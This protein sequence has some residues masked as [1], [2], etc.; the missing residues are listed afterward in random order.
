MNLTYDWAYFTRVLRLLWN[1]LCGVEL[2]T[3]ETWGH[4]EGVQKVPR[5][6]ICLLQST[7]HSHWPHCLNPSA[8]RRAM[9]RSQSCVSGGISDD[10]MLG[11]ARVI[12]CEQRESPWDQDASQL[13]GENNSRGVFKCLVFRKIS[14]TFHLSFEDYFCSV[15]GFKKWQTSA[16][17]LTKK[18]KT[19]GYGKK[20][21]FYLFYWMILE[22]SN[23]GIVACLIISLLQVE[24]MLDN[25]VHW[26]ECKSW[27]KEKKPKEQNKHKM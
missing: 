20:L 11:K 17:A 1:H 5:S 4:R 21:R 12:P 18:K 19:Q 26:Y 14:C 25:R 15:K 10:P 3:W 24:T 23:K 6:L 2:V 8:V 22:Y 16:Q 9:A 13:L 7:D 27:G